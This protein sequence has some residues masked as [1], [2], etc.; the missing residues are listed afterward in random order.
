MEEIMPQH[1]RPIANPLVV[2]REEFDNWAVLFNPDTADAMGIN[3]VGVAVWKLMDGQRTLQDIA[4]QI[5]E[6]FSE[7]P[8]NAVEDIGAFVENLAQH[9]F[10]GREAGGSRE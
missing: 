9:G 4:A 8:Q 7:V 10:V 1:D 5:G 6:R 3:P 2:L